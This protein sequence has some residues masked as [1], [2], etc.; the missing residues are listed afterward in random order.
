MARGEVLRTA[1][2][3]VS[4]KKSERDMIVASG[5][6]Q[7][8]KR[9]EHKFYNGSLYSLQTY[10]RQD[11]IPGGVEALAGRLKEAYGRPVVDGTVDFSPAPGVLSEKRTVWTDGRTEI[12]LIEREPDIE[13]APEVL[14]MMTDVLLAQKKE[15][16]R[17]DQQRKQIK[18]VPIP[19]P[20]R[21]ALRSTATLRHSG[22]ERH[23][24]L[25]KDMRRSS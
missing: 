15:E 14:L 5:D 9:V 24:G 7:Y 2:H 8:I 11:R 25:A 17:L 3:S 23:V 13:A 6:D 10:Y 1:H 21:D 4:N 18:D 22:S 16:A 12:A 19:M 20:E